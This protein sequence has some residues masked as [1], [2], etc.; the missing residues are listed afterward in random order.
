[1]MPYAETLMTAQTDGAALNTSTTQTSL[2]PPHARKLVAAGL[3]ERV[4]T[5]LKIKAA[6]RMSNIVTTPGTFKFEVKMGSIVVFDGGAM[7]LNIVAKTDLPWELDIE[8]TLRA[9]GIGTSANFM[10]F[11]RFSSFSVIGAPAPTAGGAGV[12]L[13]P[14]NTAP[15]V[16]GGFDSTAPGVLDLFGTWSISNANNSIQLHQYKLIVEN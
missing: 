14:H 5:K 8:L 13:L 3:L 15:V 4:G 9:V 12:L 11:G 2:L 1:M 7:P 10:G 6:G 16:G